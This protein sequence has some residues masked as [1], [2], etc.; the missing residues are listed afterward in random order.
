MLR[1]KQNCRQQKKDHDGQKAAVKHQNSKDG[2]GLVGSNQKEVQYG[3]SLENNGKEV[4][5]WSKQ[6][7]DLVFILS[8]GRGGGQELGL[9]GITWSDLHF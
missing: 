3:Q 2:K 5:L 9:E 7:L 8:H 1:L 6:E 4:R